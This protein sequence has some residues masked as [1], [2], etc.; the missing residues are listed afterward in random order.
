[1]GVMAGIPDILLCCAR[2]SFH[3]FFFELKA[4]KN[5]PSDIQTEW[6]Q[7]LKAQGYYVG[8]GSGDIAKKKIVNYLRLK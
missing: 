3:G 7:A 2:G 4:G 8:W 6:H 5:K 1:M